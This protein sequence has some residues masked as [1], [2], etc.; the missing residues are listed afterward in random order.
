MIMD[1][2]NFAPSKYRVPEYRMD[3]QDVWFHFLHGNVPGH[4][5][6]FMYRPE[7]PQPP[8]MRQHFSHLARLVKYIEP[9]HATAYSFAIANL[10]RDDNQHE[11]G[12]GGV[13]FVF[14]LRING[15]RDHAGRQDPPFCHAAALIDRQLDAGTLH[16]IAVQF[17]KKLLPVE[18][19]EVEGS[20]W[21][22]SQY[23][24]HAENPAHLEVILKSYVQDFDDLY[25][26]GPSRQTWR[27]SVDGVKV[28]RRVTIVHP[29]RV[30]FSTLAACMA[31]ITEVLIESNVRWTA[32]SN[33]RE[34][35]VT[36]GL[37]VR[38]VPRR[39]A[40]EATADEVLLY[41]EHVP[42]K[43][44]EIAAHLFNAHEVTAAPR[45]SRLPAP[46][47][48][49]ATPP[50]TP[51]SDTHHITSH[52]GTNEIQGTYT[53][54]HAP[55]PWER[56]EVEEAVLEEPPEIRTQG[57]GL[58]AVVEQKSGSDPPGA[59]TDWESEYK[60]SERKQRKQAATALAATV[61]FILIFGGLALIML[62]SAPKPLPEEPMA[63]SSQTTAPPK[64][65]NNAT[66][67]GPTAPSTAAPPAAPPA[68]AP[69]TSS[70]GAV[71]FQGT[72]ITP[73]KT[74]KKGK[75][76]VEVPIF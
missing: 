64:P 45:L 76:T 7:V 35:D 59:A 54:E 6:D 43:P 11:P 51:R 12:H 24:P 9:R 2:T 70:S 61:L 75:K 58:V 15:V 1:E 23:V 33:G 71:H 25:A 72:T 5:I 56:I 57:L 4:Q 14:G 21:Y 27:W 31:R 37:T 49:I 3:P 17:H 68:T 73:V 38:F 34:Q 30:D 60:K 42:D 28:P 19:S 20:G 22:R 40:T 26:P 55:K 52:Q 53:R 62:I 36:G 48:P 32:V 69:T 41:L 67:A 47:S 39:E 29:D 10:S 63:A 16:H 13:A 46:P 66:S 74:T 18:E 8:L 50:V 44:E 65:A